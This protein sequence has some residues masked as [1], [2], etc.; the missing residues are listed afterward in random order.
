MGLTPG[1]I[2]LLI[3][4]ESRTMEVNDP[5][6]IVALDYANAADAI[7]MVEQLDPKLCR[8]KVGKELFTRTGPSFV[9]QLV[10]RDFQVF[11]DLKFH[12]IPN[13][14]AGACAAAAD[15]GV[16]MMNVHASGGRRMM[17]VARERLEKYS[18]RPYL[19][20]V[21]ILT[22]LSQREIEEVGYS[23][24]PAKNV[25]ALAQLT[26]ES[27]LD[28]VVCSPLEAE[29]VRHEIADDFLLITPGVR[30]LTAKK[31]DQTR[32]MTPADALQAGSNY[33][34]IGRPITAA[35]EPLEA[36]R[37]I[38]AEIDTVR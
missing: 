22:S 20:A 30:P 26:H 4:I 15:L 18:N 16:W 21:T 11:L 37:E 6:I 24:E 13:T 9:E 35:V 28:G 29:L 32:V 23:G 38:Q 17:E 34:V 7:N 12:D 31:D 8:V 14:V 5:K 10:K 27:G 36:L 33:L 3:S 1:K 19:I 25:L 2:A